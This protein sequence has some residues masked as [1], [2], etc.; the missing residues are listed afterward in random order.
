MLE[1]L[2]GKVKWEK[3]ADCIHLKVPFGLGPL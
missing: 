3:T 2:V 1:T